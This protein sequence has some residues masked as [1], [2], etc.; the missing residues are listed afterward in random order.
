MVMI[1]AGGS[2]VSYTLFTKPY[3]LSEATALFAGQQHSRDILL[4]Q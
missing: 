4:L 2:T 1:E 3:A